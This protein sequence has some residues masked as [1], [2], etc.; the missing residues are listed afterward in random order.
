MAS[1]CVMIWLPG[2][3]IFWSFLLVDCPTEVRSQEIDAIRTRPD[4]TESPAA[5]SYC[6]KIFGMHACQLAV[7]PST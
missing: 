6:Q 2:L 5:L 3:A 4:T 1:D 7:V